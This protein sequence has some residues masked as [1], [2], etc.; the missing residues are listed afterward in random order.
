MGALNEYARKQ[1]TAYRS[2]DPLMSNIV[3]GRDLDLV[4]NIG[5]HS[6]GKDSTFDKLHHKKGVKFLFFGSQLP[7]CF[8]YMHYLEKLKATPYRYDRRFVGT[9]INEDQ[10]YEDTYTLFVR[11]NNVE[12]GK[13][14]YTYEKILLERGLLNQVPCGDTSISCIAEKDSFELFFDL[15]KEDPNIYLSRPFNPDEVDTSSEKQK[16]VAL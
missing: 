14:N 2:V 15:L 11:Y 3:I 9:I 16:M 4:K 5:R 8:T 10:S 7:K 1:K 13:G 12:L 6:I